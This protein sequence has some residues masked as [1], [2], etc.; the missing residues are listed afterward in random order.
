[1]AG[2]FAAL[3]ELIDEFIEL[4]VPVGEGDNRKIRVYRI[5]TPS[6]RDGLK[7]ERLTNAAVQLVNG[8]EDIDVEMLD[9]DEERELYEML[10]GPNF[11]QMVDDGVQWAWLRHAA[12]TCLMW[13][14]SGLDTAENFWKA[15][16]DPERMA[17][18]REARR[19]KQRASS[20][21]AKST[22]KRGSTSG[23]NHDP[24]TKGHRRQGRRK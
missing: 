20:A 18:N 5:D 19:S 17:P 10:L 13:I 23:T 4:P 3:D 9:D 1:M 15:A 12:L 7:I 8:G 6:A 22:P 21:A 11:R 16:G 2:R 24:G 14:S